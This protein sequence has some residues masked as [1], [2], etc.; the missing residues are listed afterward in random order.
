MIHSY[1]TQILISDTLPYSYQARYRGFT[2]IEM[3]IVMVIFAILS[4]IAIP[5]YR[6]YMVK[7]AESQAQASMRQMQTQLD[8]WRATN[9][10][11]RGFRPRVVATDGTVSYSYDRGD[12]TNTQISVPNTTN[13]NYTITLLDGGTGTNSLVP[14]STTTLDLSGLSPNGWR[15]IAVPNANLQRA[16]AHYLFFNSRGLT[17]QSNLP[18]ENNITACPTGVSIW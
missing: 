9:L 14:T 7:N 13:P 1:H 8:S 12:T 15:M 10:T 17:C 2:L 11:Y 6:Q 18:L 16:G 5:S 4:A 3:I